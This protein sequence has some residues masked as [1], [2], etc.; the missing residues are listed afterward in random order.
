[1]DEL[2]KIQKFMFTIDLSERLDKVFHMYVLN[3]D[4]I[5]DL[6]RRKQIYISNE[7]KQMLTVTKSV[8]RSLAM[9]N[10][11]KIT[12]SQ[13]FTELKKMEEPL[14]AN[15]SFKKLLA[16]TQLLG[17]VFEFIEMTKSYSETLKNKTL[18]QKWYLK[19]LV[20]KIN[21]KKVRLSAGDL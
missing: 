15:L 21:Y 19:L 17:E 14:F 3:L 8:C 2:I 7:L 18:S 20:P 1:M 10:E 12:V 4:E 6:I 9:F 5:E 11:R 13:L 16:S